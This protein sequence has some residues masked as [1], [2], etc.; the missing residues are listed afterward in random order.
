[1]YCIKLNEIEKIYILN[2]LLLVLLALNVLL[3]IICLG[4][5]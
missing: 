4:R 3:F 1:M 5:L 2:T